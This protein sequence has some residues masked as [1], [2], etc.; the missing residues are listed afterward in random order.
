MTRWLRMWW[1]RIV[2]LLL[3]DDGWLSDDVDR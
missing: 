3:E 1:D 2:F